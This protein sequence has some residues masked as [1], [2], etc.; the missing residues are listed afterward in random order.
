MNDSIKRYSL[1]GLITAGV[2]LFI[3]LIAYSI[4]GWRHDDIYTIIPIFFASFAL[5]IRSFRPPLPFRKGLT[6]FLGGLMIGG[7]FYF[8]WRGSDEGPYIVII[9]ALISV[10]IGIILLRK[11]FKLKI[12]RIKDN[13]LGKP[14]VK[15]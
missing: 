13:T 5:A 7:P 2:I 4:S 9:P 11:G 15:P 10:V 8:Y 3:Y 12:E 1:G 6:T 14:S